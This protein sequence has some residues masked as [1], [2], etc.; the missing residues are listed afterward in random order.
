MSD[1]E[2]SHQ[3]LKA[4][5]W[6]DDGHGDAVFELALDAEYD[7]E[8]AL[9]LRN[10][11]L[12][13]DHNCQLQAT[14]V[15]FAGVTHW[16]WR[17]A[18]M[19]SLHSLHGMDA[20]GV[21]YRQT[22]LARLAGE[23]LAIGDHLM[24][25]LVLHALGDAFAHVRPD[26]SAYGPLVGHLFAGTAPDRIADNEDKFVRYMT[27]MHA[28]LL[29]ANLSR[30]PNA[31]DHERLQQVIRKIRASRP[32]GAHARQVTTWTMQ[33]VRPLVWRLHEACTSC[34]TP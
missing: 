18:V 6:H 21:A 29:K 16:R 23:A 26:G 32:T 27:T 4:L 9:Q 25:G 14:W 28:V 3:F 5:V 20:G 13:P 19:A 33:E 34:F 15:A 10:A 31:S 8:T 1:P 12:L 11:S 30:A 2:Q 17:Q 22:V 24:A 7:K